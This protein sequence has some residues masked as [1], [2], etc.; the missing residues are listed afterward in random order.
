MCHICRVQLHPIWVPLHYIII[1]YT[2]IL[3]YYDNKYIIYHMCI[4]ML[5]YFVSILN[6]YN[7]YFSIFFVTYLLI[8]Y[9]YHYYNYSLLLLLLLLLLYFIKYYCVITV[10]TYLDEKNVSTVYNIYIYLVKTIVKT[11]APMVVDRY[12][13]IC[14]G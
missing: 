7:F 8:Y 3:Y 1:L 9:H 14:I 5:T 13:I 11:S 4:S 2:R 10:R 12:L 6:A